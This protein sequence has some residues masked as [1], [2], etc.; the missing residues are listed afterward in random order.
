MQMSWMFD[1]IRLFYRLYGEEGYNMDGKKIFFFCMTVCH[2]RTDEHIGKRCG[3]VLANSQEEAEHI[4]WD[5]Y[6]NDATCQL[7]VEE[8]TDNSYDFTVYRSEI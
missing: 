8:V 5:K 2:R 4:A 1:T 6:G 7:W 3:V